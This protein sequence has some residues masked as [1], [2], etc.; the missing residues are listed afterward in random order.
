MLFRTLAKPEFRR[1]VE[2]LL[3]QN[4]VIGPRR[5]TTDARGEPVHQFV[6][7]SRFEE[8]NLDYET[9]EFSPKTYFLPYRE[10]LSHY[11]FTEGDWTQQIQYRIQPRAIVGMH[12]CDINALVKLDKVFVKGQFP[13]PYYMSRRANTVI[14]GMDHMPGR[15]CFCR[16]VGTDT[17]ERGFDLFL[18]DLGDRYFV[19]VG[20][21]RGYGL[22][23]RVKHGEIT[24]ADTQAYLHRR[25]TI[26]E[27]FRTFVDIHNLPSILD[28]EF[29]SP[30]WRKWGQKCLSCGSCAM[31]CPTCYCYGVHECFSMDF[32]SGAKV[33]QLYSCNLYDFA[34]VAGGHNF[35]PTRESRLKYRYYHQHRGFVEQYDE[36]KCVGCN[37]CG[38]T[39]LSGINPP[40]VITELQREEQR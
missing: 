16:S 39:C 27:G 10:D 11:T 3:R 9:T 22:L 25:R 21:D 23:Q 37:R 33:K 24:E 14:V 13:S 36:P 1:M 34:M 26:A 2:D 31:V 19:N 35:R 40:E 38:R 29:D 6:P 5:V 15:L 7:V 8:L 12:A 20:S 18:S 17:V 32:G 4:E 28:I 30:V